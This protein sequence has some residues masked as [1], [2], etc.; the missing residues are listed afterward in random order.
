[1]ADIS[2]WAFGLVTRERTRK[3]AFEAVGEVFKSLLPPPLKEHPKTS[4]V[5]PAYNAAA[6]LGECLESLAHLNYPDYEIIVL[7]DGSVDPT[8][9]SAAG[10]G[11]RVLRGAR[12]GLAAARNCGI[13]A[14]TGNCVA[15]ID[16]DARADRDWLYHLVETLTRRRGA[17]AGGPNFAPPP[18]TA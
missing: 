14:A 16:A 17:A 4:V 6:T 10:G 15:F 9:E 1:G 8:G 5:V 11:G 7:G 13:E 18:T 12:R 3:R 2:D